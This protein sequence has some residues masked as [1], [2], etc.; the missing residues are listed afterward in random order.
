[1]EDLDYKIL[2]FEDRKLFLIFDSDVELGILAKNLKR[3]I[4]V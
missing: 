3:E 2:K 1:M 4:K